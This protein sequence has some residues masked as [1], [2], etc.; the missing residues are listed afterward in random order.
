MQSLFLGAAVNWLFFFQIVSTYLRHKIMQFIHGFHNCYPHHTNLLPDPAQMLSEHIC[1]R[2]RWKAA[3]FPT[4]SSSSPTMWYRSS[5]TAVQTCGDH[6]WNTHVDSMK[7]V[8]STA[9]SNVALQFHSYKGFSPSLVMTEL[10]V[11]KPHFTEHFCIT[12]DVMEFHAMQT[13]WNGILDD[14]LS[15]IFCKNIHIYSPRPPKKG[16]PSVAHLILYI[17]PC[18][19]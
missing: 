19:T 16:T 5:A 13:H 17:M 2:V 4:F 10:A 8:K 18:S 14:T 1:D 11:P 15:Y 7:L 9:A 6:Q 3:M 12:V